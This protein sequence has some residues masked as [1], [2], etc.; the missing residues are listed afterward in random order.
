[1]YINMLRKLKYT[2]CLRVELRFSEGQHTRGDHQ[3]YNAKAFL[4]DA[5]LPKIW[6]RL[7]KMGLGLHTKRFFY[8]K[9]LAKYSFR[10]ILGR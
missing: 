7:P 8:L 3:S 5:P 6:S 4:D 10:V 9:Y 1:M 2:E